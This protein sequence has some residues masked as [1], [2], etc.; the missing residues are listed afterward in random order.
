[1][2]RREWESAQTLL[3][4]VAATVERLEE[5]T[6]RV[7]ADPGSAPR[8]IAEPLVPHAVDVEWHDVADVLSLG[9]LQVT[10][11]AN[12]AYV[13]EARYAGRRLL[14]GGRAAPYDS[15]AGVY[16]LSS[17]FLDSYE[18]EPHGSW[19]VIA[20]DPDGRVAKI[21][22]GEGNVAP[23]FLRR[24]RRDLRER[25]LTLP[26]LAV[27]APAAGAHLA[28]RRVRV[29]VRLESAPRGTTVRARLTSD[30]A[31]EVVL[32]PVEAAEG[33][34]SSIRLAGEID[35]P[36]GADQDIEVV[37]SGSG[38]AEQRA[39]VRVTVDLTPPVLALDPVD[40]ADG[41]VRDSPLRV[42]GR[43]RDAHASRVSV[44]VGE[45]VFEAAAL[46]APEKAEDGSVSRPFE[47]D[48]AIPPSDEILTPVRVEAFDRA[49]NMSVQE[50]GGMRLD[51]VKYHQKLAFRAAK[52]EDWRTVDRHYAEIRRL[53]GGVLPFIHQGWAR[54]SEEPTLKVTGTPIVVVGTPITFS[55]AVKRTRRADAVRARDGSRR[56]TPTSREG[57]EQVTFEAEASSAPGARQFLVE[58]YDESVAQPEKRTEAPPFEVFVFTPE[59]Y[60]EIATAYRTGRGQAYARQSGDPN[61]S[62]A[63]TALAA[64][65]AAGVILPKAF[66]GGG[67]PIDIVPELPLPFGG[68]GFPFR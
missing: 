7:L 46:G 64:M 37:Q 55:V 35:L 53:G 4:T 63:M 50:L 16:R 30:R 40:S 43:V 6:K 34:G 27:L 21:A 45:R 5:G 23:R 11:S 44:A 52:A 54:W 48:V 17:T 12:G 31:R 8:G 2:F 41:V 62:K 39:T 61:V 66:G 68:G 60:R 51:A 67:L 24:L 14:E 20:V 26:G 32:S 1:V 10:F 49:G 42:A 57:A 19:I 13:L 47:V 9:G 15:A 33:A 22:P 38:F 28:A 56:L 25:P 18:D 3:E 65:Q 58:V 59:E 36:E 29:E